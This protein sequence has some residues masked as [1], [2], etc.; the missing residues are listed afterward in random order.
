MP[1][2]EPSPSPPARRRIPPALLVALGL[3]IG[4]FV[5]I[6]VSVIVQGDSSDPPT[7]VLASTPI[8]ADQPQIAGDFITAY[9]RFRTV[10]FVADYDVTR[11]AG[12]KVTHFTRTLVQRLPDRVVREVGATPNRGTYSAA[13]VLDEQ[14]ALVDYF[15]G[16]APL[17]R[18]ERDGECYVMD[19]YR[20]MLDPP[21]GYQARWC[22]AANG[23]LQERAMTDS[24]STET[25]TATSIRTT[26]NDADITG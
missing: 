1:E 16:S 20:A 14:A 26:V 9:G 19:L 6:V 12:D 7:G 5:A 22:F 2:S 4:V 21:M 11:E 3:A 15:S 23:A 25:Q 18:I 24:A 8:A 13:D 17:Y 10:S